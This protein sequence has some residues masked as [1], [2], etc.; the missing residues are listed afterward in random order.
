MNFII[1]IIQ[2]KEGKRGGGDDDGDYEVG[3]ADLERSSYGW[4]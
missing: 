1:I 4:I 3:C 2:R